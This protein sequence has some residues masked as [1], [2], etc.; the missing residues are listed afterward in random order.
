[1]SKAIA[2]TNHLTPELLR[3][4]LGS[5]VGITLAFSLGVSGACAQFRDDAPVP[6]QGI[7]DRESQPIQRQRDAQQQAQ[8]QQ[9]SLQSDQDRYCLQLEQKLANDWVRADQGQS[10]LPRIDQD[11][12]KYDQVYQTTQAAAERADCYQSL[13]IFGRSLRRTP[14][15]TEM[16]EKIEDARRQL[17]RLQEERKF[18]TRERQAQG[19]KD[20][21][22]NALARNG[23]GQQYAREARR[24]QGFFSW[25]SN[26]RQNFFEPR[27]GLETSRIVP[28]ATYRTLCVRLCDGYYFPINYSALPSQFSKDATACQAGCAAPARLYVYRNPG[29]ETEQMVSVQGSAYNDLK[30]AW[31]YRKEY[32][33]GCSCKEAEFD[34]AEIDK[35]NTEAKTERTEPATGSGGGKVATEA[36]P[37]KTQ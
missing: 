25:F 4:A 8:P 33:Q 24:R 18:I 31:R 7:Y 32:V 15:C 14:H 34:Q 2:L 17:A 26:N 20:D 11:I 28:Y 22:I 27:R 3:Q 36:A 12:S 5:L 9:Q 13:F 35:A 23:C 29:E 37:A 16:N 1:M 6:S 10:D 21:L 19:R 30:T